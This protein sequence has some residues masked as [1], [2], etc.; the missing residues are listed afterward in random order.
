M[1]NCSKSIENYC[2]KQK[3]RRLQRAKPPQ[4]GS[5]PCT[6]SA[7]SCIPAGGS[8]PRTPILARAPALAMCVLLKIFRI[9]PGF[10]YQSKPIYDFLVA[11]TNYLPPILH[12]FRDIAFD[13]SKLV[14]FGY[15]SCV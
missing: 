7:P 6:G 9:G 2:F 11:N 12:G 14:I 1:Q 3:H 10:W 8:A 13:N 5:A 15:P 4:G